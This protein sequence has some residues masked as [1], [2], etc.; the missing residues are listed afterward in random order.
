[1]NENAV[2]ALKKS[3]YRVVTDSDDLEKVFQL[4]YKCYRA[5]GTISANPRKIMSDAFDETENAIHVVIEYSG[6]VLAAVR[7]HIVC[8]STS[9]SPT[10]EVFPEVRRTAVE[11]SILDPTRFVVDPSARKQRLPLHFLALRIPLLAT[12]YYDIDM[13]LAPVRREHTAFYKR[14]LGYEPILNPRSYPY[15]RKPIHLLACNVQENLATVLRRTPVLGPLAEF[16]HS[17][18]E[19]KPMD[20]VGTAQTSKLLMVGG[21]APHRH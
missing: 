16:P 5:D 18:I 21:S 1:M 6:E 12:I 9:S 10:L 11:K 14:F 3:R 7:L 2:E 20:R 13:A 8:G 17:D 4:R 19:F 15:L